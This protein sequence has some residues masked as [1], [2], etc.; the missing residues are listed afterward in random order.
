MPY[1][2]RRRAALRVGVG[3]GELRLEQ[4]LELHV[5]LAKAVAKHWVVAAGTEQRVDQP[6]GGIA[7]ARE[8][9]VQDRGEPL[10]RR[11]ARAERLQPCT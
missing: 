3:R 7:R 4:A 6:R 11:A 9:R 1:A 5:H 10:D 8:H 2:T